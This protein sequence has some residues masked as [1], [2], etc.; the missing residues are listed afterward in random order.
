MLSN[1]RVN[2]ARFNHIA[3]LKES[4]LDKQEEVAGSLLPAKCGTERNSEGPVLAGQEA[5]ECSLLQNSTAVAA[6]SSSA[7]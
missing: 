5:P 2:A 1:C 3:G 6:V 4:E 7:L